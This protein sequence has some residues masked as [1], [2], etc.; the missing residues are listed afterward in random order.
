MIFLSGGVQLPGMPWLSDLHAQILLEA[1]MKLCELRC[2]SGMWLVAG[3]ARG[4]WE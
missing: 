3:L 4:S 2:V 1:V